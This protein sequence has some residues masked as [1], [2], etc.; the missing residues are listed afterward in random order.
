[1]FSKDA[2]CIQGLYR[3]QKGPKRPLLPNMP[4]GNG[5]LGRAGPK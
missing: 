4:S 1:M 3:Y 5:R 2:R